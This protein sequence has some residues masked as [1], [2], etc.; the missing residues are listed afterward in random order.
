MR[1]VI[2]FILLLTGISCATPNQSQNASLAKT[3]QQAQ[4]DWDFGAV[5]QGEVVKHDFTLKND[6]SKTFT[7]KEA[8]TSCGCTVTNVKEKKLTPGE[9]M[10]IPVKF[11]STGYSGVVSQYV[12]VITDSSEKPVVRFII[13]AEVRK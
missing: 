2:L 13:K 10:L 5:K 9:S 6:T 8:N 3:S 12:Y 7:V 4:Q 1:N 11:N